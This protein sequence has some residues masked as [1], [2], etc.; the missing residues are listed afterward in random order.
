MLVKKTT[1]QNKT[2]TTKKTKKT[3]NW[4]NSWLINFENFLEVGKKEEID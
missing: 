1:T 2:T 3:N 4:W